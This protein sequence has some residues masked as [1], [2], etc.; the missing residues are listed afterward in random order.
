MQIDDSEVALING[1]VNVL[2]ITLTL[3]NNFVQQAGE[4]KCRM[5]S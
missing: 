1:K 4:P 5:V 3:A 2:Q